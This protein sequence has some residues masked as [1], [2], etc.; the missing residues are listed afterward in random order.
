MN[1]HEVGHTIMQM[2]QLKRIPFETLDHC[3][4][5]R[6]SYEETSP[7]L[8][9]NLDCVTSK[10]SSNRSCLLFSTVANGQDAAKFLQLF[11]GHRRSLCHAVQVFQNKFVLNSQHTDTRRFSL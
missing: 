1:R 10:L 11:I 6:F 2:F 7:P 3:K 8:L 9:D 4:G 5:H